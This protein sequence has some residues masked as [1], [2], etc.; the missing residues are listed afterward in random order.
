M[1]AFFLDEFVNKLDCTNQ[2]YIYEPSF[3]L[4]VSIRMKKTLSQQ[5][6]KNHLS[7][8]MVQKSMLKWIYELSLVK[9]TR[10]VF[11]KDWNTVIVEGGYKFNNSKWTSGGLLLLS[12]Y[13]EMHSKSIF[14]YLYD[15]DTLALHNTDPTIYWIYYVVK[16]DPDIKDDIFIISI[17]WFEKFLKYKH[18][19]CSDVFRIIVENNKMCE[20]QGDKICKSV[21]DTAIKYHDVYL[22]ILCA[23]FSHI[24]YLVDLHTMVNKKS[25]VGLPRLTGYGYDLQK[26][27]DLMTDRINKLTSDKCYPSSAVDVYPIYKQI[28][29]DMFVTD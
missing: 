7:K 13:L 21:L 28:V 18:D 1:S 10:C 19:G 22:L 27:L 2:K 24:L 4:K 16:N 11:P 20:I 12:L 17:E 29:P 5:K 23:E 15:P 9:N 6:R 26:V 8:K 3:L 14:E 25:P